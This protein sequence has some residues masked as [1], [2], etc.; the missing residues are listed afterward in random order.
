LSFLF[1][2]L[3]ITLFGDDGIIGSG[4]SIGDFFLPRDGVARILVIGGF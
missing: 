2:D 3:V 1:L 4:I